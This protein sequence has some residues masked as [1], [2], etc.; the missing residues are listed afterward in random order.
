MSDND[1]ITPLDLIWACKILSVCTYKPN[2]KNS[3]VLPSQSPEADDKHLTPA[4][5][6]APGVFYNPLHTCVKQDLDLAPA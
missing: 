3:L 4:R 2:D 1:C 6:V 5:K